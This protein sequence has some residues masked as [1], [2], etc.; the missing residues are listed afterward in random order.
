MQLT[1]LDKASAFLCTINIL[2]F[3]ALAMHD[4]VFKV[5]L[6]LILKMLNAFAATKKL[7]T[8][9]DVCFVRVI[10]CQVHYLEY[11]KTQIFRPEK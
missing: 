4:D 5:G 7:V 2:N 8:N 6:T 11:T 1:F 10:F 9:L 3:L